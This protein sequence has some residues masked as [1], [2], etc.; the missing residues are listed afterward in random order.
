MRIA[1]TDLNQDGL[2]DII[3]TF[4]AP[5]PEDN[6]SLVLIWFNKDGDFI[7]GNKMKSDGYGAYID[8]CSLD[9]GPP[10]III[11][12]LHEESITLLKPSENQ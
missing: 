2:S 6:K 3:G 10:T 4:G 5:I 11:S 12:N 8:V 9:D 7:P 1:S